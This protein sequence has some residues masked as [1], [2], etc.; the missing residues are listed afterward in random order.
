MNHAADSKLV[1][2]RRGA[3]RTAPAITV[4]VVLALVACV[5]ASAAGKAKRTIDVRPGPNAISNALDRAEDGAVLRIHRGRYEE[6]VAID[7]RVK[8]V[9]AGKRRPVIDG[10]CATRSTVEARSDGVRLRHLKVVGGLAVEVDFTGVS[11][12]RAS[13][14]IVRD[15]CDAEYGVNVFGS[16][17]TRIDKS[18][19]FGFNDAGFY[20]GGITST[21]GGS[22]QLTNSDSFANLRGVIVEDSAGGDIRVRRNDLAGNDV[23]ASGALPTGV[24]ITNSD[25]VRISENHVLENAMYGLDITPDSDR[26][27]INDNSILGNPIDIRNQGSGNCGSENIF[28]TGDALPPC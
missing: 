5:T 17:P 19:A 16:G 20:I 11:G 6:E 25:G 22:I 28:G 8:L 2:V 7:K 1:A 27:L 23:V 13:E 12:G 24:L 21:P 26:N 4:L 10:E 14:L 9:S 15:T 18:R 3:R